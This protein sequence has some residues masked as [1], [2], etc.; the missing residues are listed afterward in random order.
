[1]PNF[2]EGT[3]AEVIAELAGG[4]EATAPRLA[5]AGDA[6]PLD[7]HARL[8]LNV[9]RGLMVMLLIAAHWVGGLSHQTTGLT[10]IVTFLNPILN[11][12]TPGF[13]IVFG[14]TLGFVYYPIYRTSPARAQWLLWRGSLIVAA[15]AA[16]IA[17]DCLIWNALNIYSF[18]PLQSVLFYYVLALWTAPLWLRACSGRFFTYKAF[19]LAAVFLT[20]HIVLH[21]PPGAFNSWIYLGPLLGKYGYFNLSAGALAGMVLGHSLRERQ[22]VPVW[23][24]AAGVVLIVAGGAFSFH[25]GHAA[26]FVESTDVEIW[27]WALYGGLLLVTMALFD[28]SLPRVLAWG[29]LAV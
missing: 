13:G 5:T 11:W 16:L 10:K 23:Y 21:R 6:V 22:R 25:D 29:R 2:S 12:P 4:S 18:H 15:G 24:A 20:T 3:R 26:I 28:R 17:S 14:M 27:K 9:V 8:V 1:M 7:A 19:G